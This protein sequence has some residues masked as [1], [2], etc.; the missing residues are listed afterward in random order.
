M[1]YYINIDIN[2]CENK[3]INKSTTKQKL[4]EVKLDWTRLDWIYRIVYSIHIKIFLPE[5]K[6]MFI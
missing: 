5:R 1:L 2:N 6:H 4:H 3:Q